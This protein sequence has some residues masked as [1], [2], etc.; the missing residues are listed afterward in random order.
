M[1]FLRRKDY[2]SLIDTDQ[3]STITTSTDSFL[4]DR[5]KAAQEEIS[6]YI[7]HRYDVTKIFKDILTYSFT[8]QYYINDLVQWSETAY[9]AT[10]TYALNAR[11]SYSGSIYKC[12][13]AGTT[14]VWNSSKWDYLALNETLYYCA[15]NCVGSLPSSAFTFTTNAYTTSHDD[16]KGW[17][18]LSQTTIYLKRLDDEV[19]I[20]FSA[21]DRSS[22]INVVGLFEYN[23][24]GMDFPV[25]VP[26]MPGY[27]DDNILS[28]F[29]S[30]IGYIPDL[31]EWSVVASNCW[32]EGDNRNPMILQ[33]MIDVVLYHILSRIQP[34]NIP[35]LRKERYD[36]NDPNQNSGAVGYLKRVQKGDVQ[37]DLPVHYDQERGQVFSFGSEEKQSF[38]Y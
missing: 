16:I 4:T 31:T 30:I 38:S 9:S 2:Y 36:G 28:G 34:R 15:V 12:N 14:G 29:I 7:R 24:D 19:R 26:V 3:I 1:S 18:K 8:T 23:Q 25:N 20:Y 33:L 35:D 32:V 6:S 10:S 37:L 17:D 13:T 21:A 5:E 11:V 27:N 22:N